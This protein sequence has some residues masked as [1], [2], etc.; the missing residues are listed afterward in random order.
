MPR[1]TRP[2]WDAEPG[3]VS[4]T[5]GRGRAHLLPPAVT[6][7]QSATRKREEHGPDSN[8]QNKTQR[9]ESGNQKLVLWGKPKTWP[10]VLRVLKDISGALQDTGTHRPRW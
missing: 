3:N 2:P 5:S 10:G 6:R 9:S 4:R 1:R 8:Q 7:G